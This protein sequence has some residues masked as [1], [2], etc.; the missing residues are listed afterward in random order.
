MRV[1]L[2]F[3][4]KHLKDMLLVVRIT[5][6]DSIA[7]FNCLLD[8]CD[9]QGAF[10]YASKH[11]IVEKIIYNSFLSPL[12]VDCILQEVINEPFIHDS[13]LLEGVFDLV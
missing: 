7:D 9:T 3:Q 6:D 11:G 8:I 13:V 12:N 5:P 2:H 1:L 10:N 4:R